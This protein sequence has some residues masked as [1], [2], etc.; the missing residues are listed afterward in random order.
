MSGLEKALKEYE[1]HRS[2]SDKLIDKIQYKYYE[3]KHVIFLSGK[4]TN[5]KWELGIKVVN[6]LRNR[7][8][9]IRDDIYSNLTLM[10]YP[11]DINYN[12]PNVIK[13]WLEV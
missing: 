2:E 8:V 3:S 6:E 10:G 5:F 11:V 4:D 7:V 1:A 12:D 9:Y 13:L